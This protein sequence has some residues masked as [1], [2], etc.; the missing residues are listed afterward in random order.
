MPK[1]GSIVESFRSLN[2]PIWLVLLSVQLVLG[3]M[4][5]L[6]PSPIAIL[7]GICLFILILALYAW[8][9]S[10]FAVLLITVASYQMTVLQ[11]GKINVRPNDIAVLL[12]VFTVVMQ[13]IKRNRIEIDLKGFDVPLLVVL[14][15]VVLSLFWTPNTG[16]G[17]FQTLKIFG[18]VSM[19]FII[20]SLIRD[21]KA[22]EKA[23]FI[24]F[25]IGL[26]WAVGG[27]YTFYF[28]SIPAATKETFVQGT[29]PHLGKTI[30]AS[31]FFGG[32]NDYAF[33]MSITIMISLLF[34]FLNSSLV[35]RTLTAVGIFMM[36][37]VIVVTFSRKSWLGLMLS[38]F[39]VGLMKRRILLAFII[40]S[41]IS[42]SV[43]LWAGAGGFSEALVNRV[44][45]FF[46]DPEIAMSERAK[47]WAVAKTLF[48]DHPIIGNGVGSFFILGPERGSPLNIP[49]SFYWYLLTEYGLVGMSLFA[50]FVLN[51]SAFL[52]RLLKDTTDPQKQLFCLVLLATMASVVFQSGFKTI[53]LTEPIFWAFMA[54]ISIF[55]RLNTPRFNNKKK[56][57]S[58][59]EN[60]EQR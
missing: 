24:W 59:I 33:V 4:V 11:I 2:T 27:T 15:W 53:G 46:L 14:G 19:Y 49:H 41:F 31:T 52:L 26:F 55:L 60:Y 40:F 12:G 58:L 10:A 54:L 13:W 9:I 30:R 44:A 28:H 36:L 34:Y 47:A 5:V 29:L 23:L 56:S 3:I 1:A 8:P 6:S 51:I 35:T 45:S 25:L 39:I 18:A 17:I 57:E 16:M 20:I 21:Q 22:L 32:P 37:V 50:F 7:F 48:L 42:V 38:I 43:I